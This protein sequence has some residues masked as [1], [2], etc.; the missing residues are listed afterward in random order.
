MRDAIQLVVRLRPL[1]DETL[2]LLEREANP[3]AERRP[4]AGG[5]GRR[6]PTTFGQR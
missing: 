6:T 3:L 1:F 5:F 2:A 4:A